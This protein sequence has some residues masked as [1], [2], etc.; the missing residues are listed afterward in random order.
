MIRGGRRLL[1]IGSPLP[2]QAEMDLI[3]IDD[4][5]ERLATLRKV[6]DAEAELEDAA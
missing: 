6:R 2:I 5:N 1:G 4:L 3:S